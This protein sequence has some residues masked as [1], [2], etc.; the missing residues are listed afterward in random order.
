MTYDQII[1]ANIR[2][3][4]QRAK[5]SQRDLAVLTDLSQTRI[6]RYM[7]GEAP[8]PESH[9]KRLAVAL[10]CTVEDLKRNPV[11]EASSEADVATNV[12]VSTDNVDRVFSLVRV[13]ED[14]AE[15]SDLVNENG[16]C[17]VRLTI[18]QK[19]SDLLAL[20]RTYARLAAMSDSAFS[21]EDYKRVMSKQMQMYTERSDNG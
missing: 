7:R 13:W 5:Y 20:Q 19:E 8:V 3:Y 12:A 21:Y 18:S 2:T 17:Y 14:F 1:G 15:G 16:E 4:A 10:E 6:C 9:L 11:E